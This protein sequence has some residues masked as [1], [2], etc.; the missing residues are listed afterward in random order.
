[1]NSTTTSYDVSPLAFLRFMWE[2]RSQWADSN[3]DAFFAS[4]VKPNFFDLPMPCLGGFSGQVIFPLAYTFGPE[5]L[6]SYATV[7]CNSATNLSN[8]SN[9]FCLM[10][11]FLNFLC[12]F[13]EV[14][15]LGNDNIYQTCSCS[16]ICLYAFL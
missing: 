14:R 6:S 9:L 8:L 5:E 12:Q 10:C 3:L 13:L 16:V 4:T 15:K 2:Q 1:M 7:I 11:L